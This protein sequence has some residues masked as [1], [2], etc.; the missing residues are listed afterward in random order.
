MGAL[1]AHY[2]DPSRAL[3]SRTLVRRKNYILLFRLNAIRKMHQ[4]ADVALCN[5]IPH[6]SGPGW[7]DRSG[8][9]GQQHTYGGYVHHPA[10]CF[11]PIG[12]AAAHLDDKFLRTQRRVLQHVCTRV[13][14]LLGMVAGTLDTKNP[15]K[16]WF[17]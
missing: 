7:D 17:D 9:V 6:M 8:V 15:G 11:P 12:K 16:A 3:P 14:A 10:A 1:L 2:G 13:C 5:P 4:S